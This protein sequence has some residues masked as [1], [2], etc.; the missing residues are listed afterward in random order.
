MMANDGRG[1][2]AG[3]LAQIGFCVVVVDGRGTTDRGK[4]FQD[5]VY[6]QFGRNEI[7][8]HVATLKQLFGRHPELDSSRVG[9]IGGSFGGYMTLRAML[10]APEMGT[11]MR[12]TCGS[13]ATSEASSC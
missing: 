6:G 5:V 13:P 7:P 4:Q 2:T 3:A 10:L 9:V 12:R 8:D 1:L 11:S